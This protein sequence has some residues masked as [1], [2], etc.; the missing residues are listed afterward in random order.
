MNKV[1]IVEASETDL[2][3]L[4]RKKTATLVPQ[5]DGQDGEEV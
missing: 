5:K 2:A 1:I 4:D 3:A